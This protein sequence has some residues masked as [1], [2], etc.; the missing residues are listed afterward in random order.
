MKDLKL[1]ITNPVGLH[2]RPATLF[3]K[4]AKLSNSD[5][6]VRNASEYG[7]WVD[8]KSIMA[9]LTLGVEKDHYIEVSID[10]PDEESTAQ[11]IKSLVENGFQE[12]S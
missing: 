5:I 3:V 6:R 10:G 7:S 2:A 4:C 12:Y 8:A 1:L 9:I 11:S